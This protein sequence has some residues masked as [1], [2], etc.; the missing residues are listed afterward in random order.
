MRLTPDLSATVNHYLF[1]ISN[2]EVCFMKRQ[3]WVLLLVAA[4]LGLAQPVWSDDLYVVIS[5]GGVGTPITSVPYTISQP[6]FYYLKG[7]LTSSAAGHAITINSSNVTLDL[8]GFTLTG[9]GAAAGDGI[10]INSGMRQVEVRNG[11]IQGFNQ[12]YG[13]YSTF[14]SEGRSHRLANLK[15]QTCYMGIVGDA[16]GIIITGC[17][18]SGNVFGIWS[19][20]FGAVIDKNTCSNNTNTGFSLDS[21]TGILTN[22]TAADNG[23]GFYLGGYSTQLVDRNAAYSNNANWSG[24]AGCTVGLNTP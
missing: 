20:A 23:T 9:P 3:L 11:N 16:N 15:V 10:H 5:G 1:I 6:G 7:N 4:A 24:L 12:G 13:I 19:C 17:E 8:M 21:F 14:A 22:N 2:N 18:A